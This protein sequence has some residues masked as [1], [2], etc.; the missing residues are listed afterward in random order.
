MVSHTYYIHLD[1][2][3]IQLSDVD[4]LLGKDVEVIVRELKPSNPTS[5]FDSINQ[6]L[7]DQA[8]PDF[9]KAIIDP[10]EWQKLIRDEWE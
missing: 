1:S 10:S 4:D 8:S 9:F 2:A 6:L 5:N 7:T 3:T